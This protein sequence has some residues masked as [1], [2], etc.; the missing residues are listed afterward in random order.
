MSR[1]QAEKNAARERQEAAGKPY[2]AA[3]KDLRKERLTHREDVLNQPSWSP[4]D[5]GPVPSELS[6]LVRFHANQ[7]C[8]Y[9]NDAIHRD[10]YTGLPFYDW[11]RMTLYHLTDALE[12]LNLLIGT[13]VAYLQEQRVSPERMRSNLQVRH[14]KA[15]RAFVTPS[16]LAHL[17]GLTGKTAEDRSGVWHDVGSSIANRT[18]WSCPEREDALETVLAALYANYPDDEEAF[19]NLPD[20]LREH[21][22]SLNELLRSRTEPESTA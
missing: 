1:H 16:A 19:D 17:A 12:H 8:R 15:V 22:L 10:R 18:G 13:I 20:P 2:Q 6:G 5:D 3:L 21:A 14:D 4:A 7:I 11:Q 9:L